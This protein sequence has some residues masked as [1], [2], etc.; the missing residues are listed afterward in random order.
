MTSL[1]RMQIYTSTS[2]FVLPLHCLLVIFGNNIYEPL[3]LINKLSLLQNEVQ[4]TMGAFLFVQKFQK[5]K[6]FKQIK[7][8][9]GFFFFR[10]L[11][12]FK[13]FQTKC[14]T[15]KSCLK[16]LNLVTC[17]NVLIFFWVLFTLLNLCVYK[18]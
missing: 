3:L 16:F 8:N 11:Q 9:K 1:V 4:I 14:K 5:F 12:K 15:T 10:T 2:T 6:N 7:T 17:C 13:N 18:W